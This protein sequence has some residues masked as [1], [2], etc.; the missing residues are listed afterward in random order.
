MQKDFK[1][2]LIAGVGFVAVAGLW[3]ATRP[4]LSPEARMQRAQQHQADKEG[5]GTAAATPQQT[6][7]LSG[8]PVTANKPTALTGQSATNTTPAEAQRYQVGR[9]GLSDLPVFEKPQKIRTVRL[10]TVRQGDTLSMISQ[11]YYGSPDKW[12]KIF[13]ANRQIVKDA[14]KIKSGMRLI[15]PD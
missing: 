5:L 10:Y 11:Q 9:A 4:S 12:R 15:I 8:E 3:L 14:D 6:E 2:G 7:R 13:D 1:I